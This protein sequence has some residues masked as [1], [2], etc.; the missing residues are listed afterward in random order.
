M[1]KMA[2]WMVMMVEVVVVAV[3]MVE[4]GSFL[5][6]SL[7]V[8]VTHDNVSGS[9]H[10]F[11]KKNKKEKREKIKE[12]YDSMYIKFNISTVSSFNRRPVAGSQNISSVSPAHLACPD[13]QAGAPTAA[14]QLL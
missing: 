4:G 10:Q 8:R 12:K 6:L 3:G 13:A 9:H 5:V 1:R 11:L 7:K 2:R 14:L